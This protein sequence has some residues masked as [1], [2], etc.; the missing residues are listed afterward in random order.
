MGHSE[1][2]K[3]SER[4]MRGRERARENAFAWAWACDGIG[5]SHKFPYGMHTP[6]TVHIREMHDNGCTSFRWSGRSPARR[7]MQT[8]CASVNE[9]W[10]ANVKENRRKAVR[11]EMEIEIAKIRPLYPTSLCIAAEGIPREILGSSNR[12]ILKPNNMTR[13]SRLKNKRKHKGQAG[14]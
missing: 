11:E 6:T 4:E 13:L 3:A 7:R 12:K 10:N 9:I 14:F 5:R 2:L 1:K 8:Y